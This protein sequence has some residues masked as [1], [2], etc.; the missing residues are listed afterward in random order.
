MNDAEIQSLQIVAVLVLV[1][2]GLIGGIAG[3]V[4]LCIGILL[5][6]FSCY[7][8]KPPPAVRNEEEEIPLRDMEF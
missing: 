5:M 2:G 1:F 7:K 6:L 8:V 3:T 4:M